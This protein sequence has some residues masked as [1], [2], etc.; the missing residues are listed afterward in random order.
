MA[1]DFYPFKDGQV[2]K[3]EDLNELVRSIQD[4]T[5]F[6]NTTYIS[7]QLS[8]AGTRLT[9][10]EQRVSYLESL[11]ASL[12]MRE[13][14]VLSSGQLTV[15]LEK[16]PILDSELLFINGISLS[17]TGVPLSFVGDY[18]ISGSTI[19]FNTELASQLV[20]GDIFVIQYRYEV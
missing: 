14:K 5:I 11:S 13:Q 18:S 16:P 1:L 7:E 4:G 15:G 10:I 12:F 19:T 6:L 2:L 3:A 9:G 20:D 17:K 8:N